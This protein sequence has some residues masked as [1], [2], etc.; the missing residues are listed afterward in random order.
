[1]EG[2]LFVLFMVTMMALPIVIIAVAIYVSFH[3]RTK[4]NEAWRNT[5]SRLGLQFAPDRIWGYLNGQHVQCQIVIRGS[6]K[7]KQTW[8]VVTGFTH[9][10]LDLGLAVYKQGV[11]V[12]V[13]SSLF[14]GQDIKINDP[15]FDAAFIIKGD[16]PARVA[17]LLRPDL[18]GFLMQANSR[19][20]DIQISD[21]GA[22]VQTRGGI[23]DPRW[24][25]TVLHTVAQGTALIAAARG[26]VPIASALAPHYEAWSSF[27][28]AQGL[29]GSTTPFA[30]WGDID[31]SKVTV[32]ALRTGHNM[33]H[34]QVLV[35][36]PT[37]LQHGLLVRPAGSLDAVVSFFGGQDHKIGD[38]AF[39]DAFVVKTN[40]TSQLQQIFD[41]N[42][43]QTLL[44]IKQS[45]GPVEVRDDGVAVTTTG[46]PQHPTVVPQLV[47]ALKDVAQAIHANANQIYQVQQGP[48]R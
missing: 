18:R 29:Q 22:I 9:P 14:G 39:D 24:L 37:P 23:G 10:K 3:L 31:G 15:P 16:E 2:I 33:Y 35:H 19:G 25:D 46:F 20:V 48:Y 44:Y 45:V 21:L 38:S 7:S 27:A 32:S 43:R 41:Q 11:L 8:T 17:T 28:R 13:L 40:I 42:V 4:R 26:Q 47:K 30:M 12:E 6:G 34:A 5:A 1:M 36:Y